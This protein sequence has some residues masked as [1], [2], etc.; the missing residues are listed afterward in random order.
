MTP[1]RDILMNA[2]LL[3]L[4]VLTQAEPLAAYLQKPEPDFGWQ[5]YHSDEGWLADHHFLLV[6]SQRWLGDDEVDQPLWQ[7]EVT[8]SVPWSPACPGRERDDRTALV[9]ISGG[10]RP[11]DPLRTSPGSM[12]TALALLFC[13]PVVDIRQVPNQPL[14]FA[15][16]AV[17]RKEDRLLA[18]SMTLAVDQPPGEWPLHNA[19]VKAVIASLDAVQAFSRE[20]SG[21]AAIEDFALLGSSKRGWTAWLVAAHDPRIRALVPVSI[22]M[23]NL[24]RQFDHQYAS[25]GEYTPALKAFSAEGIDCLIRSEAG[26]TMLDQVDPWAYREQLTLP[27]LVINASGDPYFV[28]D[29][30]RFYYPWLAGNNWLRYTPNTGH[31]QGDGMARLTRLAQ[32]ANWLD[33]VLAGETPPSIDSRVTDNVLE[34][35]PSQSPREMVLWQ[36]DNPDA[37][38]FRLATFGANWRPVAL[39]PDDDGVYRVSL[40][41]PAQGYRG[42]F[43]EARF[44]GWW[45]VQQQIYTSGVQVRPQVLP[46]TPRDCASPRGEANS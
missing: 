40:E 10:E 24:G 43:V 28:S 29:S 8:V 30:W 41:A 20:P 46:Y 45:G 3:L 19:M 36:A 15:G 1:A 22:D 6:T 33:Q 23:L 7:H 38:D 4:P 9:L 34:V 16:E 2:L 37:R 11:A 27:K 26:K 14:Q 39:S 13:R 12:A 25:Y 35:R 44:G 5:H 42:W 32:V 21:P 17:S 31:S 18:R